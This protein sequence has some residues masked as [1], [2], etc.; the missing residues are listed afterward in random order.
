MGEKSNESKVRLHISSLFTKK[1]LDNLEII[2][3]N[4]REPKAVSSNKIN[5]CE[6]KTFLFLNNE[7][8]KKTHSKWGKPP[9]LS[10]SKL[11]KEYKTHMKERTF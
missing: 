2:R 4:E 1:I 5:V 6:R 10:W 11:E 9:Q 3:I 7:Q 8:K